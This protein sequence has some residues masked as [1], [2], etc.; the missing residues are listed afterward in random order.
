MPTLTSLTL[1]TVYLIFLIILKLNFPT[2]KEL[3]DHFAGVY[4]KY[5][6]EIILIGSFFESLV[7]INFFVPGVLAVGLGVIFAR[8]GELDLVLAILAAVTGALIGFSLDFALGGFGFAEVAKKM[9]YADVI[10]KAEAQIEKYGLKSFSLG[11][12]HPDIGG[13]ISLAAGILK[14]PFKNFIVIAALS[15]L[16]WFTIWGLLIF[17]LGG[18]FLTILTR[19]AFVL[20]ILVLAIWFLAFAYGK[21]KKH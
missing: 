14:V 2:G 16:V 12:I 5:G 1:I 4:G 11:Y 19:Y 9:G 18:V 10:K 3:V 8:N 15:T 21:N 7:I 13:F 6:Y 20:F 17:A